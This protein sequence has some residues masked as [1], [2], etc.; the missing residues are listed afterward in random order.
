MV[1]TARGIT[2]K[3][4]MKM[5][6]A[7]FVS[8]KNELNRQGGIAPSQW[9]L[10]KFP[11]RVG[12]MLE[13]EELGQLGVLEHQTDSTTECG[14]RA[15]C[16]LESMNS[17]VRKDCSARLARA[18][19]RQ[20]RPIDVVFTAR[21]LIMCRK[22]EGPRCQGPGRIVGFAHK[23]LGTLHQGTPVAV[24]TGRARPAD[25]SEMLARSCAGL[26][27]LRAYG[28]P[29][30]SCGTAAGGSWSCRGRRQARSEAITPELDQPLFRARTYPAVLSETMQIMQ[31]PTEAGTEAVRTM[32]IEDGGSSHQPEAEPATQLEDAWM[33][34]NQG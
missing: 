33:R 18:R 4:S 12:H 5:A 6:A 29:G 2:G 22:A 7:T 20:S 28:Q 19:V 11:R 14:L 25:V 27:C 26:S 8:L 3:A 17:S 32:S 10:D 15:T 34:R 9:A 30:Q 23:V 1:A 16:L 31:H 13:E 21:D 24:A